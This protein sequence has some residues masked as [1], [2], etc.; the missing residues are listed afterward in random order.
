MKNH[1]FQWNSPLFLVIFQRYVNLPEGKFYTKPSLWA[2]PPPLLPA[3]FAAPEPLR[4]RCGKWNQCDRNGHHRGRCRKR[5]CH[6]HPDMNKHPQNHMKSIFWW[7][8]N[9]PSS[10]PKKTASTCFS[11]P[12]FTSNTHIPPKK[13]HHFCSQH[14][15]TSSFRVDLPAAHLAVPGAM[16]YLRARWNPPPAPLVRPGWD[17]AGGAARNGAAGDGWQRPKGSWGGALGKCYEK[18]GWI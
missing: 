16:R 2:F 10:K 8:P 4:I 9:C 3:V 11:I 1:H 14:P 6:G 15:Q 18:C 7:F 5:C 12:F 13:N 17:A